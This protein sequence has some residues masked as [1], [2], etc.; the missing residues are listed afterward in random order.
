MTHTSLNDFDCACTFEREIS[1]DFAILKL[2]NGKKAL[3]HHKRAWI[4]HG[5]MYNGF[6]VLKKASFKTI[7]V[8]A[9][10]ISPPH[11]G[12][13]YQ[14][15]FCHSGLNSRD[16]KNKR[17]IYLE[18]MI[19][20]YEKVV[21]LAEVSAQSSRALTT[22]PDPDPC[23]IFTSCYA[24]GHFALRPVRSG[25]WLVTIVEFQWFYGAPSPMIGMDRGNH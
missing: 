3:L 1:R 2:T 23:F 22:P 12:V 10:S 19:K 21:G 16:W 8:N 14:V 7:Q 13:E 17:Y 11:A 24:L 15:T 4:G 9:R 18:E 6:V 20:W 25:L 5:P